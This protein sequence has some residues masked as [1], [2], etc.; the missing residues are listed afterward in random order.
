MLSSVKPTLD[1]LCIVEFS[2]KGKLFEIMSYL[3]ELDNNDFP[4]SE[5]NLGFSFFQC[6]AIINPKQKELID[7]NP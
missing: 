6:F 7:E 2:I 4:K 5:I 1:H 3:Q